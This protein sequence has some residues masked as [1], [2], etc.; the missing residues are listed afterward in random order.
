[1]S[2]REPDVAVSRTSQNLL[3]LL[4]S[5]VATWAVTLVVIVVAPRY[6]GPAALGQL[7]FAMAYLQFF[8]L[9]ASL[10]TGMFLTRTVARDPSII[11]PYVFNA[12]VMKLFLGTALSVLALVIARAIGSHGDTFVL[13][14]IGCL[15]L[16]FTVWSEVF[17]GTL[18]GLERM[19]RMAMWAT[20]QVYV[21][22][23]GGVLLLVA[24][25]GVIAYALWICLA[26]I[27]PLTAGARLVWPWTRTFRHVDPGVWRT[28]V[29]GGVPLMMLSALTVLYGTIDIPILSALTDDT[30]VGW[31]TLAYRL[32]GIPVFISSATMAAFFP[33]FSA[34]GVGASD[35]FVR[36][37]NRALRLVLQV[38]IPASAAIAVLA[39]PVIDFV[40]D[41]RYAEAAPVMQILA[42]HIPLVTIGV[43]LGTA[44][45]ASDRQNPYLVVAAFA[46]V[47]NPIACILAIP[48]A[49]DNFDNGAIGAAIVTVAT[50]ALTIV[51]AVLLRSKGVMDGA[52]TWF[53][54]RVAAASGVLAGV[55]AVL[56]DV[57]LPL[58]GVVG[59]VV[60][61]IASMAMRTIN[62]D[63]LRSMS[64]AVTSVVRR[65]RLGE[66]A[67][68]PPPS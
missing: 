10:G 54:A 15:S 8:V 19:G 64:G 65:E 7:G 62:G 6:L 36:L 2:L 28:I 31:Y 27:I 1:M 22:S 4:V 38:S 13:V 58:L 9:A 12:V 16:L 61:G 14:L 33:S 56:D 51:G 40:F 55:L 49:V 32:V 23:I 37:V 45:V 53:V 42:V 50:E 17:V 46:A 60:Y 39:R 66:T 63:D 52:T 25:H 5:Q 67:T 18:A 26:A 43:V 24:G 41:D 34:H 30:T 29:R 11:G 35:E 20:V 68:A 44:L 48:W 47:F 21:A 3:Y 59:L 57:P